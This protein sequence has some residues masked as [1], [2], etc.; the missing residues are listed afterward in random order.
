MQ[1]ILTFS[2]NAQSTLVV[3]YSNP[4]VLKLARVCTF[5]SS[6][7]LLGLLARLDE[8]LLFLQ[9]CATDC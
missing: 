5:P 2:A 6:F 1:S 9:R 4:D 8:S 7:G 3:I